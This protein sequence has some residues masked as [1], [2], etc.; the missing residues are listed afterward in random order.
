MNI[1]ILDQDPVLA[2]RSLADQHIN[3]MIVEHCQLLATAHHKDVSPYKHTHF[4][5]PCAKWVRE[6]SANYVWLLDYTAA[7]IDE[8]YF[9]WPERA[10]HKSESVWLW[11]AENAQLAINHEIDT[12]T[13]FAQAMPDNFRSDDAVSAY[14]NYYRSNKRILNNRPAAWTKRIRPNWF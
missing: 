6:S 13:P 10:I 1:F 9:R 11:Y 2:A 3:K 5:H 12:L 14:R 7:L 8:R 4:N